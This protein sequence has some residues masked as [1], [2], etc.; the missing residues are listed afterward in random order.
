M[1]TSTAAHTHI[2]QIQ[3]PL[4]LNVVEILVVVINNLRSSNI[5]ENEKQVIEKILDPMGQRKL[6]NKNNIKYTEFHKHF[7][8]KIRKPTGMWQY[9]LQK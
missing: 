6:K 2:A 9:N 3:I 8:K 7:R 4:V 1:K 5:N